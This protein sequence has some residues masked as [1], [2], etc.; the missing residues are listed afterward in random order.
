MNDNP[1]YSRRV[2]EIADYI[3]AHPEQNR[4]Q[5]IA[6]FCTLLHKKRR[7]VNTLISQAKEYNKSRIQK[8]EKAKDDALVQSAKE[9][10]KK[11]IASRDE[12]LIAVSRVLYGTARKVSDEIFV[13]SDS[14]ILRA[15]S[16]LASIQGWNAPVKNDINIKRPLFNIEVSNQK[17]KVKLDKFLDS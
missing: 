10:I 6:H 14:D 5:Y 8:Q 7:A 2:I 12:T 4:E 1:T 11:G 16:L 9:A 13:P 3:F 15:A 17:T